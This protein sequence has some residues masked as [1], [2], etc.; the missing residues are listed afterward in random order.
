[1]GSAE[2]DELWE[3]WERAGVGQQR[4]CASCASD[5][6][7]KGAMN[8]REGGREGRGRE[9]KKE[10]KSRVGVETGTLKWGSTDL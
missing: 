5:L 6:E 1:M 4:V 8:S 2:S 9:G 7:E 10:G 3:P